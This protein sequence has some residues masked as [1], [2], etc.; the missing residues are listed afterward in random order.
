M[1]FTVN[2]KT[3]DD[4]PAPGQCLRTFLR[5]LGHFGVKKGCD[6]GDCGACTVYLD[7]EPVH[8]CLIPAFRAESHEVTTI[9]GLAQGNELHPMQR[10]F[11]DAQG[12]QCG[13]CTAGMI[14]TA[15]SLNQAQRADLARSMK[16]NL[17]RCTGYRAIDDAIAGRRDTEQA[18]AGE[19]IGHNVAAPAGPDVVTGKAR[20]TLDIAIDGL[21]H[22][23]LLRSPHAHARIRSIDKTAALAVPGVI[24]VLTHEDA[25]PVAF[26][27]ARHEVRETDVDDTMVLDNVVRFIGQRVAAVVAD[28]EAAAEEGCRKL[29]VD[30]EIRPA[31][32]DPERAMADG[33]PVIHDKGPDSRI[34][35]PAH[36]IV[37]DVHGSFGD[38]DA[39][40]AEADVVHEGTYFV[41]RVQHAHLET[42]CAIAWTDDAGRLNVRSST[43]VPF[44]TRLELARVFGLDPDKVRVLCERVGGGFGAKQEMMVEDIAA[45]ATL[46]TGK[47]VKIEFTREEQFIAAT[48]RH[49]MKVD[50]K[51]GARR[52][53]TLTAIRMHVIS[54]T[55]AYGN[56][57]APVLEHACSESISVYRCP[58]KKVDGYAVYTNTVP[59][60]AF[61]GYGLPQTS[62]A[63]EQAID[64]VARA[65]GIN[66]LEFR[67]RNVVKPGEPMIGAHVSPDDVIYGSYGLDQCLDLVDEAMRQ[68][69]AHEPLS[70]EWLTGQG[71]ALTMIDTVPPGGHYS[72][73][74]IWLDTDGGYR[75]TVGT[76]EFGNGTS[77]VHVQ[78]AATALQTTPPRIRYTQ[79]DTD[80]YGHDTGAYGS[81]GTVIAG[82]ATQLAAE[83]LHERLLTFAAAHSGTTPD[84]CRLTDGAVSC[85]SKTVALADLHKA[86]Q[87][88]GVVLAAHGKTDGSPRSVAFNVQGFK[89][90]VNRISGE[91]RILKSV[92]A[93]DAGFVINPMQCRAQ[94]EGGVAQALGAALFEEVVIDALGRVANPSFR[95][96]HIP[97]FADVPRTEVLFAKTAD[98]LGPY[99]AKSMSES[100]YNP[101]A[102]ALG[103]A[104]RDATGVRY[105]RLPFKPDRIQAQLPQLG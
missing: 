12:F 15:A 103:N 14:M 37:A 38:V 20:F 30:Y 93:A 97:A 41:P 7:G 35:D 23:K 49:P 105:T 65:L 68:P 32:F 29:M 88:A 55:G 31:V 74:H 56:H 54:N 34:L 46:K 22:I 104:I 77:T 99:G 51:I 78:V 95:N 94:V 9:E 4:A 100:P 57:G 96:Y 86:A 69:A 27:T 21:Q 25:P 47:P 19:S 66:A 92:Q 63:V 18:Q 64:E 16:G 36:N 26:S 1:S 84:Q 39:G 71:T 52:D 59:A 40:F 11:L 60:G 72:D 90:A 10:A 43:Q 67:R 83:A 44:L 17:C 101:V 48:T 80:H 102:A 87:T 28:S 76:A 53:G 89:V 70:S 5:Q 42:L 2:G 82:R 85:A 75:M 91:I 33:A 62:F 61:R 24:A 50:I 13:F 81:T 73:T 79:S 58:N 8:S 3:F 45:L 98:K 6:A